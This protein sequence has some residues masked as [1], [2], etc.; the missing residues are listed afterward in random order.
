VIFRVS[1]VLCFI[2]WGSAARAADHAPGDALVVSFGQASNGIDVFRLAWRR[3]FSGPLFCWHEHCVGGYYE[4]A[5]SDW[6]GDDDDI[7]VA[8][9]SPVLVHEFK[10]GAKTFKPYIELGLGAALLSDTRI[11]RRNLSSNFVFESRL[12]VGLR[13]DR[14]DVNLRFMHDS[15]AGLSEPNDGLSM[16]MVSLGYAF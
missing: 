2:L 12:G 13:S 1:C 6:S 15:N 11:D 8:S 4:A 10:Q 9:F 3:S 7:V 5:L 14:L 16:F